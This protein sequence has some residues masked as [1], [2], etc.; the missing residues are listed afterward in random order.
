[1]AEIDFITRLHTG[2]K[3]NYL[4]RVLDHNKAE[5]AEVA[6]RWGFDYWDGERRFGYG[7]YRYDGRWRPVAERMAAHYGLRPGQRVMDVGC[8]K[9]YLLYELTQVVP[10]LEVAGIDISGYALEHAKEE[11]QPWLCRADATRLPFPD[12]VFDLVYSLT[13]LHNLHNYQL[14]A[15]LREIQRVGR[16]HRYISVESYRNEREKAN[17]LYWQLTC[18]CFLR[19]EE[20]CWAFGQAGYQ[21]DYGFIYF[22]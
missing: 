9:A 12:A 10:G 13:T 19:P 8:G 6:R 18:E 16:S 11:V 5:C 17:L 15:A 7:G 1:M 3:R 4:R 14:H 21:G 20:W 22:D 2:T